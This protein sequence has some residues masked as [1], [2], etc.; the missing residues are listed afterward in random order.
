MEKV[1]AQY[2]VNEDQLIIALVYL[3]VSLHLKQ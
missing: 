2:Y 1:P 3:E